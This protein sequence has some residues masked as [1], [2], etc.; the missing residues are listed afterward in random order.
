MVKFWGKM[1]PVARPLAMP[2]TCTIKPGCLEGRASLTDGTREHQDAWEIHRIFPILAG[3]ESN[4]KHEIGTL[5][6]LKPQKKSPEHQTIHI[7]HHFPSLTG[8]SPKKIV[9]QGKWWNMIISQG[10]TYHEN[11]CLHRCARGALNGWRVIR[12]SKMP[13]WCIGKTCF[14]IEFYLYSLHIIWFSAWKHTPKNVWHILDT[15]KVYH[16][17]CGALCTGTWCREFSVFGPLRYI[18]KTG[19]SWWHHGYAWDVYYDVLCMYKLCIHVTKLCIHIIHVIIY[20]CI[21]CRIA[22]NQVKKR[23][24]RTISVFFE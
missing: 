3:V 4:D 21:F 16:T 12:T 9:S 6:W 2:R 1:Y 17:L 22:T 8:K 19:P 23:S 11:I 5:K 18:K 15:R 14:W 13:C 20:T 24:C 7:F 10:P